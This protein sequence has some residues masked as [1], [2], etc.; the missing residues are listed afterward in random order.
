MVALGMTFAFSITVARVLGPDEAGLVFAAVVAVSGVGMVARFGSDLAVIRRGATLFSVGRLTRDRLGWSRLVTI[1]LVNSVT[2]AIVATLVLE[3]VVGR[4]GSTLPYAIFAWSV[5]FQCI[6]VLSSALLRAANRA[7]LGAFA[8]VGLAQGA[9]AVITVAL[10][11]VGLS[12]VSSVS[13]GFTFATAAV[14][15]WSWAQ[16]QK[17][18]QDESLAVADAP[19]MTHA[20]AGRAELSAT[21]WS[22]VLFYALTWSPIGVL[23]VLSTNEQVSLYGAAARLPTLIALIPIVQLTGSLPVIAAHVAHQRTAEGNEVLA[24]LNLRATVLAVLACAVIVPAAPLIMRIFGEGFADAAPVLRVLALGQ[25][26]VVVLGPGSLI[27]LVTGFEREAMTALILTCIGAAVVES[28]LAIELGAVGAALG[29]ALGMASFGGAMAVVLRRRSG[30]VLHVSLPR[31][32][33]GSRERKDEQPLHESE[34]AG[35]SL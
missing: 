17:V 22:S 14:G 32:R 28:A 35:D 26:L 7:A 16:A 21:M 25:L 10:H 19:V 34:W 3:L 6:A 5:P 8:E 27:P 29:W 9:A 11:Q 12:T 1:C 13:A 4:T 18:W 24:R 30:I 2:I 20:P 23:L 15:V 33:A 31:G